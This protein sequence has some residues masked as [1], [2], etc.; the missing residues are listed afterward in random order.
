MSLK[1]MRRLMPTGGRGPIFDRVVLGLE[2]RGQVILSRDVDASHIAPEEQPEY[3]R[4]GEVL[5]TSIAKRG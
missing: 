4:E 2:G 5:F 1:E 3:I